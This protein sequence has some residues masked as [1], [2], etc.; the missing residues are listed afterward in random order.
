MDGNA[1]EEAQPGVPT[2]L[3]PI[4]CTSEAAS[5]DVTTAL[6]ADVGD[7]WVDAS[8]AGSETD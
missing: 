8:R 5:F 4:V 7:N 6:E 1:E 2:W 3:P